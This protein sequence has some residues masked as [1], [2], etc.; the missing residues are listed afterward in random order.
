MNS[1]KL[2]AMGLALILVL[3]LCACA[4][5]EPAGTTEGETTA[6]TVIA[7]SNNDGQIEVGTVEDVEVNEASEHLDAAEASASGNWEALFVPIDIEGRAIDMANVD[8]TPTAE[9]LEAM[10]PEA[11]ILSPG[12]GRPEDAGICIESITSCPTA[13]P[14]A[15][16][17]R[18][19]S[20][21]IRKPA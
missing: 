11:L 8:L 16:P 10:K 12:P 5:N 14:P 19:I 9:E 3:S 15:P 17:W 18:I 13:A 7:D 6:S 1:K 4:A 20:A 2:V 21:T